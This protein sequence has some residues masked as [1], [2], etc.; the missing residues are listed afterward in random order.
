MSKEQSGVN[1]GGGMPSGFD[2]AGDFTILQID[3]SRRAHEILIGLSDVGLS[4]AERLGVA[5]AMNMMTLGHWHGAGQM[6]VL[7]H[8]L[9]S[10]RAAGEAFVA[11]SAKR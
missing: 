9:S 8:I 1:I 5:L 10:T 4:A 7:E 6:K 2:P 3:L 11:E